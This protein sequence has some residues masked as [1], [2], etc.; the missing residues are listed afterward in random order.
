MKTITILIEKEV[1]EFSNRTEGFLKFL[2][3]FAIR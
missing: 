3:N 1:E 2:I